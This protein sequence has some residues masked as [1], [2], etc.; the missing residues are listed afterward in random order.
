MVLDGGNLLT[1]LPGGHRPCLAKANLAAD[2]G[3]APEIKNAMWG[4]YRRIL[5]GGPRAQI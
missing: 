4:P 3:R 1:I 2:G 5:R